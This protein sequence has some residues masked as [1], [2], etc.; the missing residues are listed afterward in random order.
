MNISIKL[1][2]NI[3]QDVNRI[4]GFSP[5]VP[6]ERSAILLFFPANQSSRMGRKKYQNYFIAIFSACGR[7]GR[8]V[9]HVRDRGEST[10]H[11]FALMPLP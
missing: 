10:R 1:K 4:A 5:G 7:D 11:A 2:N 9:P 3:T 8:Q 6:M